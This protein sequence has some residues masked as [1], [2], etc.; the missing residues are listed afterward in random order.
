M[1]DDYAI[2][3]VIAAEPPHANVGSGDPPTDAPPCVPNTCQ[4]LGARCGAV[5]DGCGATLDCGTCRGNEV[6]G[7]KTPNHCDRDKEGGR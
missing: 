3:G 2:P 5:S 4:K 1:E 7:L 6:C